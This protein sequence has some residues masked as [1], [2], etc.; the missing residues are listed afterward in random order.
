[1][2]QVWVLVKKDLG[3]FFGRPLFYLIAGLCALVWSPIYIYTF[4]VFLT[5][6]LGQMGQQTEPL[7]FHSRVLVEFIYL[8]NFVF[9]LFVNGITMKLIAE[10]RKSKTYE[11]LMTAPITTKQIILAK[12]ISAFFVMIMLLT[13]SFMYPLTTSMLGDLNWPPL[14]SAYLGLVLFSGVYVS[15]GLLASS[16][17][18]SVLVAFLLA[19]IFNLGLWFL[20]IGAEMSQADWFHG[21]FQYM[22]FEPIFK[23]FSLGVIRLSSIVY[24]ICLMFIGCFCAERILQWTRWR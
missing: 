18:N 2:S 19:L 13:I 6:V 12:F 15:F 22:N 3:S 14:L 23:S 7:S 24:L 20:G 4:G 11:L 1:M 5:Q 16:M 10:E 8:I 9:L 21:V 17:S